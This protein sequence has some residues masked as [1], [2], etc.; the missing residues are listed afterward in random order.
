[1]SIYWSNQR[2]DFTLLVNERLHSPTDMLIFT[3]KL[4]K[5]QKERFEDIPTT[6][7]RGLLKLDNTKG[8]EAL[9]PSPKT[10]LAHIESTVPDTIRKRT[11]EARRWLSVSLKQLAKTTATVEDFVD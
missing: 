2:I 6:A 4:F 8:R 11:D 3:T 1:M 10:C 7:F 5:L 9:L